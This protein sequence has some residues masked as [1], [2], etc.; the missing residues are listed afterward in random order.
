[1]SSR[2]NHK[3]TEAFWQ[4]KW[5][6]EKIFETQKDFSKKRISKTASNYNL[7]PDYVNQFLDIK[8]KNAFF[9]NAMESA[10][11]EDIPLDYQNI[12]RLYWCK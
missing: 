4:E 5:S 12:T 7:D 2:Y 9:I 10:L 3:K 8:N 6:K 11:K 1:M